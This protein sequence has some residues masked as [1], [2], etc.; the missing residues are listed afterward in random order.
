MKKEEVPSPYQMVSIDS[1]YTTMVIVL[2]VSDQKKHSYEEKHK[3]IQD[4]EMN[5][6]S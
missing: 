1:A 3:S 2:L 4:N 5:M 6:K